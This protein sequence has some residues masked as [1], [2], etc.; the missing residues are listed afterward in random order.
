MLVLL[1]VMKSES[2]GRKEMNRSGQF[3]P[4]RLE[5][6]RLRRG[7]TKR[8]LAER[9]RISLRNLA[10]L[11][12]GEQ[13][14]SDEVVAK[15]SE[16]LHFPQ[17]F[18]FND[19]L[20]LPPE[21][22][23][24]FRAFSRMPARLRDRVLAAGALG[25]SLSDWM[26]KGFSLPSPDIPQCEYADPETAAEQVRGEWNLREDQPIDSMIYLLESHGAR[27][28]SLTED[29]L[30][31]DAYSFWRGSV[32]YVFLNTMKSAERSRM[33]AAH[34]LGHL[35]L[36]QEESPQ[37]NRQAEKEANQFGSAFLMP[38]ASVFARV[39]WGARLDEIT[40]A[41]RYWKV[42]VANLTYR[43]RDVGLLTDN[44]Y[45]WTF[46]RMG[47]LGYRRSEPISGLSR[48]TSTVLAMVFQY[49]REDGVSA[50]EVADDLSIYP[51]ELS[52]L[53]FGLVPFPMPLD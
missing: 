40:E 15:F 25:I 11:I 22:K 50:R 47:R 5:I 14:P 33:D 10:R 27:V 36:H 42:S 21:A 32:P 34:E 39:S 31:V 29:T 30:D 41:R 51:D 13:V 1:V 18:F 28:F 3:N 24:S 8:D 12:S 46:A 16:T 7:L 2:Y 43:L 37:R 45:R 49:L 26:D 53:L 48:E 20:E 9:A 23:S 6:A 17:K 35:V 4:S 19:D 52:K 38:R 44:Q